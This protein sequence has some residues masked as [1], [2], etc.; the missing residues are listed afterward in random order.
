MSGPRNRPEKGPKNRSSDSGGNVEGTC[1]YRTTTL[2][3]FPVL[4]KGA[5]A[6]VVSWP[7]S[8]GPRWLASRWTK[9]G[10]L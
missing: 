6:V 3:M 5:L 2:G 10:S 7:A 8:L 4:V 1:N 9:G